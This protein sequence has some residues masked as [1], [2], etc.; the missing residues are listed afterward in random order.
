M[1]S[2]H[3][4]NPIFFKKKNKDLTSR[5][6]ANPLPPLRPITSRFCLTLLP[7]LSTWTSYVHH[8]LMDHTFVFLLIF[9]DSEYDVVNV[10]RGSHRKTHSN[11]LSESCY[12]G[13][14]LVSF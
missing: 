9:L 13:V 3:G 6:F 7:P 1:M 12:V 4:I 11:R 2:G 8:P 5:T 14:F 10:L